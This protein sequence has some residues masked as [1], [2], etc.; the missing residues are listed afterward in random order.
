M[1]SPFDDFDPEFKSGATDFQPGPI[2]FKELSISI[3]VQ[4]YIDDAVKKLRDSVAS[5][6][7]TNLQLILC[8]AFYETFESS[9]VSTE[10]D[11]HWKQFLHYLAIEAGVAVRTIEERSGG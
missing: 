7:E 4:E 5:Q 3:D 6:V 2:N 10:I 11:H 8:K 9:A 1:T